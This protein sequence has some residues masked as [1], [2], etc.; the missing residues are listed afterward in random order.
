L[1]FSDKSDRFTGSYVLQ[2]LSE[3]VRFDQR[4]QYDVVA[5]PKEKEKGILLKGPK[6]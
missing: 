3:S 4:S 1:F 6:S 5:Y 2:P